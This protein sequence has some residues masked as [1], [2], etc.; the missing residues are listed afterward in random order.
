MR[1]AFAL[2]CALLATAAPA[3]TL[4]EL[5][6]EFD[7]IMGDYGQAAPQPGMVY[8]I[9]KDGRL[10]HVRGFGVQ[11]LEAKRPVTADSLFRI[12]SMSKAFTALAVLKLRDKGGLRLDDPAER[13]VHGAQSPDPHRRL[14]RGQPLG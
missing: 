4:E 8:G 11:D 1:L 3:A 9:V 10:I 12:A 5:I 14:R 6:P 2:G 13:Y 7:R